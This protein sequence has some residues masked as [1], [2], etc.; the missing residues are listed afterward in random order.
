MIN[1]FPSV[2][3]TPIMFDVLHYEVGRKLLP[4]TVEKRSSIS[5]EEAGNEAATLSKAAVGNDC[6]V[7]FYF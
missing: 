3:M 5:Q 2:V 6:N 4:N 1:I 7:L